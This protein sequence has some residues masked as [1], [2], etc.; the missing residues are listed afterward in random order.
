MIITTLS[1]AVVRVV[2]RVYFL[3]VLALTGFFV[4]R[5][6]HGRNKLRILRGNSVLATRVLN[7]LDG[8]D[9][10]FAP[11]QLRSFPS[12][13]FG[14]SLLLFLFVLGKAADLLTT[15]LVVNHLIQARCPFG[16]GL[17]FGNEAKQVMPPFNGRPVQVVQN[18]QLLAVNNSCHYGI[19]KKLN[20]AIN[21]CPDK[22]DIVGSWT[23]NTISDKTPQ[24]YAAGTN[25]TYIAEDMVSK[26]L[27]DKNWF[28]ERSQWNTGFTNH[29]VIWSTSTTIDSDWSLWS[30][31]AAVQ[32]TYKEE[33][34]IQLT[35]LGCSVSGSGADGTI[36]GM[37]S[38]ST[39]RQWVPT[40]QGLM[41]YGTNS[42]AISNIDDALAMLLNTMT[43]VS[44]GNNYL[45]A[46]PAAGQDTTQ[47]CLVRAAY[48]TT[49]MVA[50]FIV[51]A[52]LGITSFV[53]WCITAISL[54]RAPSEL[55]ALPL[56]P[57]EW[58]AFAAR[59]YLSTAA[60]Q[61][62]HA[63]AM[64]VAP[65]ETNELKTFSMGF[66]QPNIG[67]IGMFQRR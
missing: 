53:G 64:V 46:E 29:L 33:D 55:D 7:S 38:G 16:E 34:G 25:Y 44:G 49:V 1:T 22:R 5:I 32:T 27:M 15:Y 35:M 63:G 57:E 47:G 23:C 41:Y 42:T 19:Y 28:L 66:A 21:F 45:L 20:T 56:S 50:I 2:L 13:A 11:L 65:V 43:M 17:V 24:S 58:A 4:R 10:L 31:K 51:V 6:L 12:G 48:V 61:Q 59:E 36:G 52:A 14:F 8:L 26:G 67:R 30:V 18:A 3:I 37:A 60:T 9:L 39:L 40:F 62:G 54:F